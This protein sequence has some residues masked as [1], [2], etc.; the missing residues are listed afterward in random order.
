[1]CLHAWS[2]PAPPRSAPS[3]LRRRPG[4]AYQRCRSCSRSRKLPAPVKHDAADVPNAPDAPE[5]SL[6]MS[7]T[8]PQGGPT[9]SHGG[10]DVGSGQW[11][12]GVVDV[13]DQ[14]VPDR[15]KWLASA[16]RGALRMR[17]GQARLTGCTVQ[18]AGTN[19]RALCSWFD[20]RVFGC[21]RLPL[22]LQQLALSPGVRFLFRHPVR[23][24]AA[25]PALTSSFLSDGAAAPICL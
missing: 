3:G 17:G 13:G 24:S 18:V 12:A 10:V 8:G 23:L 1:M 4:P 6:R 7:R 2:F 21:L 25:L 19:C 15:R 20:W 14:F 11:A 5:P 22:P 9:R 16:W